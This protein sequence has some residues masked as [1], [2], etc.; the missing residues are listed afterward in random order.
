MAAADILGAVCW[1]A[2]FAAPLF[3]MWWAWR[4]KHLHWSIRIGIGLLIGV[5]LSYFLYMISLTL[6]FRDGMGP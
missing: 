4:I 6:I 3:T 2:V 1:F 5:S